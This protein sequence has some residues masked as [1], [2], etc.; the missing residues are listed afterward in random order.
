MRRPMLQFPAILLGTT[1]LVLLTACGG[2][3]GS[4]APATASKLHYTNNPN[5]KSTDWRIE[6]ESGQDTAH[7]RLK[8]L[9]PE[10]LVAKGC[11]FFLTC[12]ASHCTWG[13]T[14]VGTAFAPGSAPQLF[15]GKAGATAADIQVGIY[16]K[17]GTATLG[18]A[19]IVSL[20]LDLE[21]GAAPGSASLTITPSKSAIYLDGSTPGQTQPISTI[22]VGEL[23]AD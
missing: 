6:V 22:L 19:S 8:L 13:T 3:G 23:R 11:S 21:N 4:K 7:L 14:Q 5:A 12:D 20:A 16:Q 17:T 9:G 10:A 18:T 1:A 15:K 2:G